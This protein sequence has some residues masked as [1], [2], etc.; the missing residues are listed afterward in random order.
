MGATLAF[1]FSRMLLQESVQK[2]FGRYL[3][4]ANE[5]I[6][7][8]GAFYLFTRSK[9]QKWHRRLGSSVL[10]SARIIP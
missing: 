9:N 2:K 7:K 6:E 1:L 3:T 10:H 5:G 4:I 8:D